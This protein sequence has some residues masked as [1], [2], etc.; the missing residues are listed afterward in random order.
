V[1]RPD[2]SAPA[3]SSTTPAGA[4]AIGHLPVAVQR[5]LEQLR[6]RLVSVLGPELVA[7]VTFGSAVRG[8]Y[9]AEQS[10]VDVL[11]VLR[12]P[13]PARLNQ[14]AEP[15]Q[16]ARDAA[17]VEVIVLGASEIPR[18]ADVF[19]LFYDD[20]RRCHVVLA[21]ENP[22]ATLNIQDQHRR[23]RIEQELREAH[24]RLRR[25]VM[26]CR[27]TAQQLAGGVTRKVRQVRSPLYALLTL[28]K[29]LPDDTVESVLAM[30]GERYKVDGKSLADPRRVREAPDRAA[31]QLNEL[32]A[33][34]ID[35][36]D[37]MEGP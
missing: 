24:I 37:R 27:G 4:P 34:A 22:L 16:A 20:I 29:L 14:V 7:L 30:A 31:E 8:G 3:S 18:A 10:D 11:L 17:R 9:R 33:R 23:L 19:P 35:E 13:T 2:S 25:V 36:V 6:D 5:H 15:I 1:S 21:G 28:V 26:D 32:L 12:D